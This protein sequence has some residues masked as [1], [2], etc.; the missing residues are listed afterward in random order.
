MS[1]DYL[2]AVDH[3]GDKVTQAE[4]DYLKWFKQSA[5]FGPADGDVHSGM[6]DHYERQTGNKV[7][8]DWRE[9]E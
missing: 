8:K 6:N 4:Y 3:H 1:L 7:P 9:E 2:P 5:D